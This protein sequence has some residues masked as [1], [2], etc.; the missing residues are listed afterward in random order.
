MKCSNG[1]MITE[2]L[3]AKN[4]ATKNIGNGE[5][6]KVDKVTEIEYARICGKRWERFVL[7][8]LLVGC[9]RMKAEFAIENC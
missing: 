1:I 4:R 5:E 2:R 9:Y 8:C 3:S 7:G 6:G